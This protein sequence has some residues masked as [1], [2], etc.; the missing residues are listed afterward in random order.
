[1]AKNGEFFNYITAVRIDDHY[2][3]VVRGTDRETSDEF[4]VGRLLQ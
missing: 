3:F 2:F 1:M 4:T